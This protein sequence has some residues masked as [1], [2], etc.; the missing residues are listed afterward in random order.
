[1]SGGAGAIPA[2][3][4][5]SALQATLNGYEVHG[6]WTPATAAALADSGV[7]RNAACTVRRVI[8]TNAHAVARYL[9]IFDAAAVPADA[10]APRVPAILVPATTTIS[11]AL[12][13]LACANGL[14][15]AMSSTQA[16]KTITADTL[17]VCSAEII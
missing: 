12:G 1:L 11:V 14:C 16:T 15:W 6:T 10:T 4:A 17:H 7:I 2:G 9:M 5:T 3:A 8:A 13:G